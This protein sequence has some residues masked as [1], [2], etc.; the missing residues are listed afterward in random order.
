MP[1]E[2]DLIVLLKKMRYQLTALQAQVT[3]ALRQASDLDLPVVEH[4][5]PNC[6]LILKGPL[7]LAEHIYTS[8]RGPVPAH[9]ERAE[10]MAES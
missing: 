2:P 5:C 8:H 7:S 6:L 9:W 3:E 1:E 4:R 10:E